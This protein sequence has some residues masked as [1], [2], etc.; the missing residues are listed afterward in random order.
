MTNLIIEHLFSKAQVYLYFTGYDPS[1]KGF[2]GSWCIFNSSNHTESLESVFA[3]DLGVSAGHFSTVGENVFFYDLA[4]MPSQFA[5]LHANELS[6]TL[7]QIIRG[8][9]L[10][11]ETI[12]KSLLEMFRLH[13]TYAALLNYDKG[14][15]DEPYIIYKITREKTVQLH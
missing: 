3:D 10:P 11:E 7:R 15:I 4:N 5:A 2:F 1:G 14:L 12:E 8:S 9:P 13:K 6:E